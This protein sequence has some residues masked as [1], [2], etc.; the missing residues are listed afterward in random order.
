MHSHGWDAD[1]IAAIAL[2]GA[3]TP[4]V[5]HLHVS[6]EW[7]NERRVS[8][9]VRRAL[10]ELWLSPRRAVLIAVAES[11]RQYWCQHF[12]WNERDIYVVRNGI[13]TQRFGVHQRR[14]RCGEPV[15]LG[16]VGRLV[17]GKGI[18]TLIEALR[19][20]K[21]RG[22]MCPL[23]IAGAGPLRARLQQQCRQYGVGSQVKFLG[24]L[25]ELDEFYASVDLLVHPSLSEGL[26]LVILEAM[27]SGLPIVA[28][29]V[30]G[31]PEVLEHAVHGYMVSP[32]DA[33]ALASAITDMIADPREMQLMGCRA[34]SRA[35]GEFCSRSMVEGVAAVYEAVRQ[36]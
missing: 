18:E 4:R 36:R 8:A 7:L 15:R 34:R 17:P 16:A 3:N 13:E 21:S 28:T 25:E 10:T 14:R 9:A 1:V 23:R 22:V 33:R 29:R 19:I 11:V 26:P 32:G 24:H 31:V 20:L 12:G 27:A 6:A 5:S 35:R 30:G 2:A